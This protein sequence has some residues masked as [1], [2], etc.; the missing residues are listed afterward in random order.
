MDYPI[1][2]FDVWMAPMVATRWGSIECVQRHKQFFHKVEHMGLHKAST[3]LFKNRYPF[4][5][6][7]T[8]VGNLSI[9]ADISDILASREPHLPVSSASTGTIDSIGSHSTTESLYKDGPGDNDHQGKCSGW[10]THI[11]NSPDKRDKISPNNDRDSAVQLDYYCPLCARR[12]YDGTCPACNGTRPKTSFKSFIHKFKSWFQGKSKREKELKPQCDHHIET[13]G[14]EIQ[15]F[16][17]PRWIRNTRNSRR[18][19]LD[20]GAASEWVKGCDVN[21]N[22]SYLP[23]IR[24]RATTA[25]LNNVLVHLELDGFTEIC[26]SLES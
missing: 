12:L 24:S 14:V 18:S 3:S 10:I 2:L 22:R 4:D 23:S 21:F 11:F 6:S 17:V 19:T 26:V 9:D 20:P 15:D 25:K 7:S 1:N 5:L 8:S 16:V 13:K